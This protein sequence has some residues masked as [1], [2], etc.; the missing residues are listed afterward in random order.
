M[1][2]RKEDVR[3]I[4]YKAIKDI[5]DQHPELVLSTAAHFLQTDTKARLCGAGRAAK[6]VEAVL[7][8]RLRPAWPYSS[9]IVL[10]GRR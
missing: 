6:L 9:C 5:G 3:E 4:N 1:Y 10:A 2:D 7:T 8:V